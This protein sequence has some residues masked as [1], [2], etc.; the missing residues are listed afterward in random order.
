MAN[1]ESGD[2]MSIGRVEL[3]RALFDGHQSGL[4]LLQQPD[5]S[6]CISEDVAFVLF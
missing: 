5:V 1:L 4:V 3:S 2:D 6:H